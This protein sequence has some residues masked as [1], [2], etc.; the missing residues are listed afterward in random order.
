[1]NQSADRINVPQ[2]HRDEEELMKPGGPPV[3]ADGVDDPA[4]AGHLFGQSTSIGYALGGARHR[5]LAERPGFAVPGSSIDHISDEIVVLKQPL[6]P[7]AA[8]IRRLAQKL[9]V[10]WFRG[11]DARSALSI[12]SAERRE[13][14]TTL[15]A[16]LACVYA[17]AGVRTLLID[18]DL[19][20][21]S[22]HG[23]FGADL[24]EHDEGGSLLVTGIENLA[25]ISA[26]RLFDMNH[27]RVMPTALAAL[28]DSQGAGFDVILVDTTAASVSDDY[29]F[30]GLSTGGAIVVTREGKSKVK[31][32]AKMLNSCEDAGLKIVGGIMLNS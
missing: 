17:Q 8:D 11:E 2:E 24:T 7:R 15:A 26:S 20:H 23:L 30:A 18:A 13:G 14:R 12:I 27:G 3:H 21:P 22:I 25:I 19:S 6:S 10:H 1:V 5:A 32:T 28:I 16:N 4:G 29:L 9:A 31:T